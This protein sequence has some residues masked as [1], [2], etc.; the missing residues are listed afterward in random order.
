MSTGTIAAV[1]SQVCSRQLQLLDARE[2]D[3]IESTP[4]TGTTDLT[5]TCMTD[6]KEA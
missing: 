2:I 4:D 3:E 1:T 5:D 6:V